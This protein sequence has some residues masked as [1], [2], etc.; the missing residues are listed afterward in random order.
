MSVG[1]KNLAVYAMFDRWIG[2]GWTPFASPGGFV[3]QPSHHPEVLLAYAGVALPTA[4]AAAWLFR[5]PYDRDSRAAV[6]EWSAVFLAAAIFGTLTWKHYLVVLLLPM[7]LFVATWRDENVSPAFRRRLRAL[8]WCAFPP[9][10]ACAPALLGGELSV[11]L[12]SG[13]L[14]TITAL[15]LLGVLF[16]YRRNCPDVADPHPRRD[17]LDQARDLRRLIAVA[18]PADAKK[19]AKPFGVA[20]R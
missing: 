10:L 4:L 9:S 20:G 16:W 14:L 12:E 8:T 7:T 5:G 18:Y 15:F 2:H 1:G 13:S 6:A 17:S 11:R 3:L 19:I